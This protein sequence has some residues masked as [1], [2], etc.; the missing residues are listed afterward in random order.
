MRV[1]QYLAQCHPSFLRFDVMVVV[2]SAQLQL[3][4]SKIAM[5]G[6]SKQNST[7]LSFLLNLSNPSTLTRYTQQQNGR[8]ESTIIP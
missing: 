5:E 4:A 1:N 2:G 7:A 6:E 3:N 8:R